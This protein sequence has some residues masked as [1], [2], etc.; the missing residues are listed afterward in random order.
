MQRGGLAGAVWAQESDD[1][2]AIYTQA[3]ITQRP[4]FVPTKQRRVTL[5]DIFELKEGKHRLCV[6]LTAELHSEAARERLIG[7]NATYQLL[8][9]AG[10]FLLVFVGQVPE[11][12]AASESFRVSDHG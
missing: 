9:T 8:A 3:E 2:S 6:I 10:E 1:L 5:A 11:F 7:L 4:A 12:H